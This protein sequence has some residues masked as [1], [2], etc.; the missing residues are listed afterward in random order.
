MKMATFEGLI[1][2]VFLAAGIG[3]YEA[4]YCNIGT[5]LFCAS[6]AL[7]VQGLFERLEERK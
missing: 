5:G 6:V 3:S 4:G 1:I 7:F 2:S